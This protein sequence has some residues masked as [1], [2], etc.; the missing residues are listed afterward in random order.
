VVPEQTQL[1]ALSLPSSIAVV[2]ATLVPKHLNS[3]GTASKHVACLPEFVLFLFL[4]FHFGSSITL[5]IM[6]ISCVQS[7]LLFYF[8]Q[9]FSVVPAL[10]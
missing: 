9:E 1:S 5:K 7:I 8:R 6:Y 3:R 2:L 10:T 4:S